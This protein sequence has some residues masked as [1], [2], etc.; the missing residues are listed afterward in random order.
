MLLTFKGLCIFSYTRK[1]N[2]TFVKGLFIL[3]ALTKEILNIY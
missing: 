2:E 1:F 3:M